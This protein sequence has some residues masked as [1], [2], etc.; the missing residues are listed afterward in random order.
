MTV[1]HRSPRGGSAAPPPGSGVKL[2]GRLALGRKL[3]LGW[4]PL[5]PNHRPD[6]FCGLG[7]S[8]PLALGMK[9]LER[10]QRAIH[11]GDVLFQPFEPLGC[12]AFAHTPQRRQPGHRRSHG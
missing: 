1:M 10:G 8:A 12:Q 6:A 2:S 4:E 3:R 9:L 11:V 7:S 5:G